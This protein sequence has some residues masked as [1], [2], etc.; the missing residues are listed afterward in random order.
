[1]SNSRIVK[2]MILALIIAIGISI[3]GGRIAGPSIILWNFIVWTLILFFLDW[4][5][6]LFNRKKRVTN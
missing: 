4:F 6:G 5:I 3:N 1:M 2:R